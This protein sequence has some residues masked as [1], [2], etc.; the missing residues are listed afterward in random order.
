MRSKRPVLASVISGLLA[1]AIWFAIQHRAYA[2]DFTYGQRLYSIGDHAGALHIWR[3]LAEQGDAR[4]QYSLAL[5]YAKGMGV[6]KDVAI[7]RMWAEKAAAQNFGPAKA[8]L[9]LLGPPSMGARPGHAM[10]NRAIGEQDSETG[11]IKAAVSEILKQLAA[12]FGRNGELEHGDIMIDAA[13]SG[14]AVAVMDVALRGREGELL[15]MGT[16]KMHV[17]VPD[18]GHFAVGVTLPEVL[19][20][21]DRQKRMTRIALGRQASTVLWNRQYVTSTDFAFIYGD[22]VMTSDQQ[23]GQV[24]IGEL[25]AVAEIR[26]DGKHWSGP[27]RFAVKDL[28]MRTGKAAPSGHIGALSIELRL[29][30][31]DLPRYM[32]AVHGL[33]PGQEQTGDP[34]EP[35]VGAI[36]NAGLFFRA[37]DIDLTQ[38]AGNGFALKQ[39]AFSIVLAETSADSAQL[40]LGLRHAGFAS[41]SP[42]ADAAWTPA[43]M[44]AEVLL[45]RIPIRTATHAMATLGLDLVLFGEVTSAGDLLP[46]LR[47]DLAASG[48]TLSLERFEFAS[49]A[50]RAAA[51]GELRADAAAA[52]GAIGTLQT[53][54]QGL[55]AIGG[56][57]GIDGDD[58]SVLGRLLAMSESDPSGTGQRFVVEL[59]TDGNV[60]VN[61]KPLLSPSE[62]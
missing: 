36:R 38:M 24:A 57:M 32:Q 9:T 45:D 5:L 6:T 26:P 7:A 51:K 44:N 14:Y 62:E 52:F 59:T 56:A 30:G 29:D 11:Q 31:F 53:T 2:T 37:D 17:T 27:F 12:T 18:E 60:L 19:Y 3:P 61:D 21:R 10:A 33:Q 13:G 40:R 39:A 1:A 48:A 54:I 23:P 28:S 50:L 16:V 43:A 47:R 25:S 4:A 55:K 35:F 15:D 49:E 34:G 22:I 41:A 8:M 46:R 20:L 42:S 58:T